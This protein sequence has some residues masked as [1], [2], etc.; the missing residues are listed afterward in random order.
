MPPLFPMPIVKESASFCPVARPRARSG[1]CLSPPHRIMVGSPE[2]DLS[3][4]ACLS[5]GW[6]RNAA[7]DRRSHAVSF[8]KPLTTMWHTRRI[9]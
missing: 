1:S 3:A 5:A 2:C 7:R 8:C 4:S 9:A 6:S